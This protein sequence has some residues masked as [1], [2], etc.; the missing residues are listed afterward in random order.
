[1]VLLKDMHTCCTFNWQMLGM[2]HIAVLRSLSL[3]A[4]PMHLIPDHYCTG[5]NEQINVKF[6]K[7]VGN[8]L[9]KNTSWIIFLISVLNLWWRHLCIFSVIA[10][11]AECNKQKVSKICILVVYSIGK[12]F[13]W[14][15]SLFYDLL[16]WWRHPCIFTPDHY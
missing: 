3:V 15:I 7:Y 8:A 11:C 10:Y 14:T 5:S 4:P 1:M 6:C 13:V 16:V 2:N 9:Y 12:S